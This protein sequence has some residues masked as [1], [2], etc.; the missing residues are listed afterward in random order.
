MTV[1]PMVRLLVVTDDSLFSDYTAAVVDRYPSMDLTCVSRLSA[2][3]SR[4]TDGVVD[5]VVLDTDLPHH[6]TRGLHRAIRAEQPALPLVVASSQPR[7]AFSSA[8]SYHA[9]VRKEGPAM[10]ASLVDAVRVLTAANLT[11]HGTAS[12]TAE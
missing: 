10:G 12:A 9:F 8:L 7:S 6:G 11:D 3:Q 4:V 2:A 1:A 5:C